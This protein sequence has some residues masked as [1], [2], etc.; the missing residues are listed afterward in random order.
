MCFDSPTLELSLTMSQD[1]N[2]HIN[3]FIQLKT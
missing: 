1:M 2:E 3:N